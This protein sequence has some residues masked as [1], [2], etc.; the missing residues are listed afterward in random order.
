MRFV[1]CVS[2]Q[3]NAGNG[4]RGAA[5]FRRESYVPNGGPF[6]GDGG[7]GGNVIIVADPNVGSLLDFRYKKHV[8]AEH[9]QSGMNKRMHGRNGVDATVSVP[10]GTI[11]RDAKT[12]EMLA[13]LHAPGMQVIAAHGGRGGLG[14][15]HFR[16]STNQAPSYAQPGE[17]G[18]ERMIILEIKLLA[19]IGIIGYPSV[20]KSTLISVI[21]NARPKIAAYHFTTLSP[22]LGIVKWHDFKSFV[23]ADIPGLIEHASEGKGLGYRFLRHIERCRALCHVLEVLPPDYAGSADY[24]V[25]RAPIHDF[26]LINREL[27]QFSP[28]LAERPQIVAVS[29]CELPWVAEAIPE[30]RAHF[31]GL[32]YRFIAFSSVTREGLPELVDAMGFLYENTPAP[33]AAHFTVPP[34]DEVGIRSLGESAEDGDDDMHFEWVEGDV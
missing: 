32:G 21:S 24:D 3:L 30:L 28:T 18:E 26:E 29:K 7:S 15:Y 10:V 23:V 2:L 1:D 34:E 14:N 19:D 22:N 9:G 6:G 33:D 20:G 17:A 27:T 16:T 13:D 11:I 25:E 8:R 12:R 5:T 31:E 4:G